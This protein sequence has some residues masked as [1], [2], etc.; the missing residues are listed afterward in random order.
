MTV[1]LNDF[2]VDPAIVRLMSR[3]DWQRKRTDDAWLS[4]FPAHPESSYRRLPFVEF[5]GV[6]WAH[7][8]NAQVRKPEL[9]DLNGAPSL[10]YPPGDFDPAAGYIIGF[11]AMADAAIC[12]DLRPA[13]GPRIIYDFLA[14]RTIYATAFSSIREFVRFYLEKHGKWSSAALGQ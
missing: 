8:E 5:C 11:T 7:R 1:I 4:R 14:P 6:E 9:A 12:A 2:Q 10:D 13:Q 3:P